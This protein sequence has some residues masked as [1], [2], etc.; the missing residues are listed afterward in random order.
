MS[1]IRIK[2]GLACCDC[3]DYEQECPSELVGI[4]GQP[5]MQVSS[6]T[7]CINYGLTMMSY[8]S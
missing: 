3:G 7:L 5:L 6:S 4:A 1:S 2:C 8:S